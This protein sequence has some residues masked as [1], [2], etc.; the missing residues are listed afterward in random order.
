MRWAALELLWTTLGSVLTGC[1]FALGMAYATR[2]LRLLSVGLTDAEL[3]A[4]GHVPHAEL[5]LLTLL[6]VLTFVAS[7][8]LG[9]SGIA[10]LFVCGVLSRH[11]TYHNLSVDARKSATSLF[12]TLA[13]LCETSLATLLGVAAFHYLIQTKLWDAPFAL[14]TL[15]C[16]FIARALNIF[17]LT[18]LTNYLRRG[19]KAAISFPMQVVMW[20][21]GMRGALSFALVVT[22]SPLMGDKDAS[23]PDE[24]F[25]HLAAATLV[26]IVITTMFMAPATRPLIKIL[27][28]GH[29]HG[30]PGVDP[31][32]NHPSLIEVLMEPATSGQST[33]AAL[34]GEPETPPQPPL[35]MRGS[36]GSGLFGGTDNEEDEDD[37][38]YY[39]LE[40]TRTH[41]SPSRGESLSFKQRFRRFELVWIKPIFGGRGARAIV[42]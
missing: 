7:E 9:F 20:F 18:A 31:S 40:W 22:L 42:E 8:R 41:D 16:L 24:S 12:L 3:S 26:T 17:P 6:G 39:R 30:P 10:S 5:S 32:S 34:A 33:L 2:R 36:Y 23:L 29:G 38:A 19:R 27:R 1:S 35:P 14:L 21:S 25:H 4:I 28:V 15:P 37:D 11:Y 13:T